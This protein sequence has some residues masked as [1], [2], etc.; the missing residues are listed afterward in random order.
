VIKGEKEMLITEK[1]Y[2]YCNRACGNVVEA[3]TKKKFFSIY[4]LIIQIFSIEI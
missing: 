3:T 4:L 2:N 1:R